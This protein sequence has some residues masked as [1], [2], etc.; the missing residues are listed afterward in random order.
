LSTAREI[1][2]APVDDRASAAARGIAGRI[3]EAYRKRRWL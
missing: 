3:E 2:G 1:K